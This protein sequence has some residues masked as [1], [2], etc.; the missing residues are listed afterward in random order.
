[1]QLVAL[2]SSGNNAEAQKD[3]ETRITAMVECLE[4]TFSAL[5][6][7]AEIGGVAMLPTMP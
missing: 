3:L 1:M 7:T 4:S 6:I 2:A 5:T